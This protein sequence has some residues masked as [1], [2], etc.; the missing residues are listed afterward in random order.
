[1]LGEWGAASSDGGWVRVGCSGFGGTRVWWVWGLAVPPKSV[2]P[3]WKCLM[4]GGEA[5]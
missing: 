5:F 2:E 1:M 4:G 3:A